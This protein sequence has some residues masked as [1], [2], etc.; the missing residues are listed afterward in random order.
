MA[1]DHSA[2]NLFQQKPTICFYPQVSDCDGDLKVLKSRGKTVVTLD[3]GP[4]RAKE[5]VLQDAGGSIYHSEQLSNLAP[6][7]CTF[8]YDVLVGV[9]YALFVHSQTEQ[10]IVAQLAKQNVS[11][12]P[13]QIGN[14]GKKFIAY[15][16]IAHHQSRRRVQIKAVVEFKLPPVMFPF[17]YPKNHPTIHWLLGCVM[18]A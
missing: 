16:A 6:H 17:F 9:G 10:Q 5:T 11:I 15:L 18:P 14:L 2:A 8:G 7:R 12:S 13:R 1:R 4:F 3:I